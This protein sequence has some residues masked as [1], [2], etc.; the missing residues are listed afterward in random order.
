MFLTSNVEMHSVFHLIDGLLYPCN[1]NRLM[2]DAYPGWHTYDHQHYCLPGTHCP[3]SPRQPQQPHTPFETPLRRLRLNLS[4]CELWS[5]L[6][7]LFLLQNL[8]EV[9]WSRWVLGVDRP[10]CVSYAPVAKK[11][12]HLPYKWYLALCATQ[13]ALK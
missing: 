3:Q 10:H 13:D 4:H 7:F 12:I 5:K 6:T 1:I 2:A 8:L 11:E 9:F